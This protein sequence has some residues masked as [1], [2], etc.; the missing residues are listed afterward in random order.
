MKS[1]VHKNISNY[2]I[3]LFSKITEIN[4]FNENVELGLIFRIVSSVFGVK[5]CNFKKYL[6]RNIYEKMFFSL[7]ISL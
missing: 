6:Q 1:A 4:I 5:I 3:I 7:R 2:P